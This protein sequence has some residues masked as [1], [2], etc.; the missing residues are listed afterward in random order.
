M[1]KPS[2]FFVCAIT[3]ALLAVPSAQAKLR[4]STVRHK[5]DIRNYQEELGYFQKAN[6]DL[7]DP[8]FMFADDNGRYEFGVGGKITISEFIGFNGEMNDWDLKFLSSNIAVPTDYTK[9]FATKAACSINFKARAKVGKYKMIAF[10]QLTGHSAKD[11]SINQAYISL[12]GFSFG[13]I[14]SFFMDLEVGPMTTGLGPDSP[15]DINHTLFGYTHKFKNGITVAAAM[16]NA[17]L[18]LDYYTKDR[19]IM[20]NF[21]PMPDLVGHIKYKWNKGHV[22]LGL[23]YRYLTYWSIESETSHNYEGWSGH[24]PGYGISLS[25]NFKPT[26]RLKLSGQFVYGK[27]ISTYLPNL[28]DLNIDVGISDQKHGIYNTV[29]GIPVYDGLIAVQYNWNDNWSTSL[30]GGLSH[31]FDAKGVES[32]SSFR[33]SHYVIGNVFYYLK[34]FAYAGLE[35]IYGDKYIELNPN[36]LGQQVIDFKHGHANRIALSLVFLF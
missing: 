35:Y 11:I 23:L 24:T 22:Q 2:I 12:G 15:V 21:Q 8:R 29:K 6:R 10:L 13:M 20:S 36:L 5:S 26:S 19:L 27:G 3:L 4:D 7:G 25:A 34:D 14:P 33:T 17:S 1:K 9:S 30:L 31:R 16:E 32:F 18:D 28:C